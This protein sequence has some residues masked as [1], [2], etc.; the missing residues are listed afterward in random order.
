MRYHVGTSA[1]TA[2]I[3]SAGSAL[4]ARSITL[5]GTHQAAPVRRINVRGAMF[6]SLGG[7]RGGSSLAAP[8]PG[9]HASIRNNP[10]VCAR[11][12]CPCLEDVVRGREERAAARG[13]PVSEIMEDETFMALGRVARRHAALIAGRVLPAEMLPVVGEETAL[14]V[15]D[16]VHTGTAMRLR[17]IYLCPIHMKDLRVGWIKICG[18]HVQI[19]HQK[20]AKAMEEQHIQLRSTELVHAA[21][22]NAIGPQA[23][24][25]HLFSSVPLLSVV[26][27]ALNRGRNDRVNQQ[28]RYG[29]GALQGMRTIPDFSGSRK[30]RAR[31]G[32]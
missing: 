20:R 26:L 1:A 6:G 29:G 7:Y 14:K 17:W 2:H 8:P 13:E 24:V 31:E 27:H 22:G 16:D 15:L 32:S 18:R 12:Q 30:R 9:G 19:A 10:E 28:K 11:G 3:A 4:Y 5:S 25:K 21:A 23:I